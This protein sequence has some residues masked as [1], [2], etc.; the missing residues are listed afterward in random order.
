MKKY[1]AAV[2]FAVALVQP[3]SAITFSKLTTIYL[4]AGVYDL[5]N[6]PTTGINTATSV[7]CSNVSG[8]NAQYRVLVLDGDGEVV[9]QTTQNIAHG[10]TQTVSTNDVVAFI[11]ISLEL[12]FSIRGV[13]NVEATQSGIFCNAQIVDRAGALSTSSPLHLVRVNPHPGT[14]E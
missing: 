1:L 2:A 10:A 9:A 8:L 12:G 14:V 3:A 11:D 5:K 13:L 7:H 6:Y 4:G